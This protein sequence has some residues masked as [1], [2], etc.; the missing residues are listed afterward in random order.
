MCGSMVNISVST[1]PISTTNITG[2]RHIQRGSS[3]RTACQ[4]AG[5]MMSR[6]K[7]WLRT[8]RCFVILVL[9]GLINSESLRGEGL[10]GPHGEV[11]RDWTQRQNW[12]EGQ[13][14]DDQHRAGKHTAK[15]TA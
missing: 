11:L 13:R 3:L 15:E 1:A 6:L 12:E 14:S 9:I 5:T 8:P 7:V 4:R 2:F 10:P